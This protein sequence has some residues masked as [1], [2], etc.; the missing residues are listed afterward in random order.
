MSTQR[1]LVTGGA[2]FIGSSLC[3]RL[4]Q[5]G[6]TVVALDSMFRGDEANLE[7]IIGEE[8]FS[9]YAGDVRDVDDLDACVE[10]MGGLDV[11]YHLA[12]INGTKWFHEA[13]HSVI[14]VNIN[15]TLRTLELAMA[16]D[17]RYVFA[18][19]PEAFG[20][21]ESQPITD[22]DAM[23]FSDPAQHQRHSYGGS[24]YLGEVASQHATREG[25]DVRIVRPFNAYGPRLC[26]DD[27]GQ[28]IGIFFQNILDGVNL[29][30]HGDGSQTRSFT[31]IDDVVDGFVKAGE[32]NS[33]PN[34]VFNIGSTEEIS[35][36]ELA[37]KVTKFSTN[38]SEVTYGDGYFGDSNRRL[39]EISRA[40]ELLNWQSKVSLDDGLELMWDSLTT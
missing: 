31:W 25:L 27:Y 32:V 21:P 9:L 28:V 40:V 8:N 5:Q 38:G 17:A 33:C 6:H 34:M 19:S 4:V 3:E 7:E 37:N 20:E 16:N 1:I 29:T 24:K 13:A 26:G 15:G 23:I 36:L 39:P 10:A 18:S 14:D 12:A 35:I 22:G 30:V 2:G 11:I